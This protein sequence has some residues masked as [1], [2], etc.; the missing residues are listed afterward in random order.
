MSNIR[1][2]IHFQKVQTHLLQTIKECM[3]GLYLAAAGETPVV[4]GRPAGAM[5]VV[6]VLKEAGVGVFVQ[7][8]WVLHKKVIKLSLLHIPPGPKLT[9]VWYVNLERGSVQDRGGCRKVR[10]QNNGVRCRVMEREAEKKKKRLGH[11][12]FAGHTWLVWSWLVNCS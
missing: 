7:L 12:R 10:I 6:L 3:C 9:V 1:F 11:K 2:Y 4:V 5:S 8:L